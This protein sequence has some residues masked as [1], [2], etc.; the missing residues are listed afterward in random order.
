MRSSHRSGFFVEA[1]VR[2]IHSYSCSYS[3][4]EQELPDSDRTIPNAFGYRLTVQ[5]AARPVLAMGMKSLLFRE[6]CVTFGFYCFR[7]EAEGKQKP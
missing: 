1:R 6:I 7:S 4:F 2:L 3:G 5:V